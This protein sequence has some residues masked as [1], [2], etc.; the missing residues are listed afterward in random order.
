MLRQSGSA[1]DWLRSACRGYGCPGCGALVGAGAALAAPRGAGAQAWWLRHAAPVRRLG[2]CTARRRG[3]TRGAAPR[4]AGLGV[5]PRC[6]GHRLAGCGDSRRSITINKIRS[7]GRTSA[8][9]ATARHTR[10]SR[11]CCPRGCR[12]GPLWTTCEKAH[13]RARTAH[14]PHSS[15]APSAPSAPSSSLSSPSKSAISSAS[16]TYSGTTQ[17]VE[18][19]PSTRRMPRCGMEDK[20]KRR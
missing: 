12:A 7:A 20:S 13:D 15:S 17:R 4:D 16:N 11:W 2:G 1:L 14:E 5:G 3:A 8:R 19:S 18:S 10:Q 9:R 6:A